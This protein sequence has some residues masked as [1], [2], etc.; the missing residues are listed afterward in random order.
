MYKYFLTLCTLLASILASGQNIKGVVYDKA[1]KSTLPGANVF[2][3][4]TTR[5]TVTGVDGSFTVPAPE[6]YP[7]ELIFSFV[8]YQNDS[9]TI[10]APITGLRIYLNS[11]I[12]MN[13]VE[14]KG[15]QGAFTMSTMDKLNTESINRGVLRKA[16]CCNLSES[17]ETTASVDVVLND[18]VT[19]TRKIQML[20]LA[21]IYVQNLFEGIPFTRGLANVQGFDQIPG[22]WIDAIQ[23]TKGV[24]TVQN[25][26]ESMTGQINLSFLQPDG[27]ETFYFDGFANSQSRFESNLVWTKPLNQ[28][29]STALYIGANNEN[30][31]V[32]KNQDGFMDMPL[33][34]GIKLMNRWKFK[35]EYFRSQ[36]IGRYNR[37]ERI[38]GQTRF[39][40][41]DDFG[42]LNAYGFGMDYD[43]FEL[44]G[45]AGIL[46]RTREDRSLGITAAYNRTNIDGYF[47]NS[48]YDGFEESGRINTLFQSKFSKYSD[49][50]FT[51]GLHFLYDRYEES[52]ADSAFSREEIVPGVFGEYTYERPR[53]TLVAGL[54]ADQHNLFGTQISPRLHLKYNLKPLTTVRTTVGRGFRSPNAFAD[55]FGLLAS[56]RRIIIMDTP[57]AESSWNMGASLLHKFSIF[58]RDAVFN[59][60]YYYTTFENQLVVD[61]DTDPHKLL[62][63]NLNDHSDAHSLQSDFQYELVRGLAIKLSYKYQLV[64]VDYIS[65]QRQAPLIPKNRALVNLGYTS[66]NGKWYIDATGN[67]YGVSRLPDTSTNPPEFQLAKESDSFL[68]FNSQIT[69]TFGNFEVYAGAENI[70]NFIQ[71]DAIVDP[72]NPFGTNFDATM[73]YGPLNGRTFYLG[74]RLTLKDKQL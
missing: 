1:T 38:G 66:P 43:Q 54:R 45:K 5:G 28:T 19:G 70:G 46:S 13:T 74:F 64:T 3:M 14:V 8:G 31:R 16:A 62:F 65:G 55:Q 73:I 37:E 53:F 9:I 22:P 2:W 61:R 7:A 12:E 59:L 34:R 71:E 10:D 35:K 26:Y 18:A 15:N 23:L 51:A 30:D 21:G 47:G 42:T 4:G 20:G 32:D 6:E 24:G 67:Y 72:E 40:Y 69:R 39:R 27:P 49:H 56:S 36:I 33:S 52:L 44:M 60:D 57:E 11:A 50:S 58:G 17:F 29:W 25:G 41:D 68:V 48:K 63:Y